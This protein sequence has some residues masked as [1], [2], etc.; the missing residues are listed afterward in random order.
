MEDVAPIIPT[1]LLLGST[2]RVTFGAISGLAGET[3]SFFNSGSDSGGLAAFG[4]GFFVK[5]TNQ[6]RNRALSVVLLPEMSSL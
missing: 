2:Y 5:F 1:S 3:G 6:M 4:F